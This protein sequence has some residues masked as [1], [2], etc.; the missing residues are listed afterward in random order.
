MTD[1]EL[2]QAKRAKL[3]REKPQVFEKVL[4]IE[5]RYKQGIA[6]PI[7]DIAYSYACNLKCQH[8]TASRFEKKGAEIDACGSAKNQR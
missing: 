2:E 3:M 1:K 5:E 7:I 4:K 6:T 8:C